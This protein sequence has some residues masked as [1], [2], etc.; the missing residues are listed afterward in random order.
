MRYL[1]IVS[2]IALTINSYAQQS[3]ELTKKNGVYH[4]PCKVNGIPMNFIFDTGASEVTISA[5]EAC[6]LVKQNLLTSEDIIGNVNYQI[7]NGEIVEGTKIRLKTIEIGETVLKGVT[8]TVMHGQES[9]LLLGQSAISK[10][11]EYS[12]N[13]NRLTIQNSDRKLMPVTADNF[14]EALE[15]LNHF[16]QNETWITKVN[17]SFQ[18][19]NFSNSLFYY[20]KA[21]VQTEKSL[22]SKSDDDKVIFEKEYTIAL[23]N[24]KSINELIHQAD[25]TKSNDV[26]YI[27]FQFEFFEKIKYRCVSTDPKNLIPEAD[28]KYIDKILLGPEKLL[29]PGDMEMLRKAMRI[30]FRNAEITQEKMNMD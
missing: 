23:D 29:A 22:Y 14:L 17:S 20:S 26:D 27:I 7:A 25:E 13:G 6:F 4:L 15:Y 2:I 11:G 28:T 18:Y 9:P 21:L 1:L 5:T 10:L 8:A 16:L 30:I 19:N 3:I 24:V 12:I